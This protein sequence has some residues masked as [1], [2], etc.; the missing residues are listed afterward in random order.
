MN[1]ELDRQ[2]THLAVYRTTH[3]E[4]IDAGHGT[5]A[6]SSPPTNELTIGR[7]QEAMACMNAD[8]LRTMRLS[9]WGWAA[10][11]DAARRCPTDWNAM[12]RI[13]L[14]FLQA[15]VEAEQGDTLRDASHG[16]YLCETCWDAMTDTVIEAGQSNT[17]L[18]EAKCAACVVEER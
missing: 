2:M 15:R 1:A 9:T 14:G 8:C 17:G 12:A 11:V 10:F 13:Q 18:A 7:I 6:A 16:Q 5:V 4:A 3:P